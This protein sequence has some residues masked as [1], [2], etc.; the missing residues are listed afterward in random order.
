ML[1]IGPLHYVLQS[2]WAWF[3]MSPSCIIER[4][5]VRI[6]HIGSIVLDGGEFTGTGISLGSVLIRY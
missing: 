6:R 1:T 3:S 5:L 2:L 4:C